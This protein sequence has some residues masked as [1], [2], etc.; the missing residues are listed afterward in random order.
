MATIQETFLGQ[1]CYRIRIHEE[2]FHMQP[3]DNWF[4]LYFLL[5]YLFIPSSTYSSHNP[6]LVASTSLHSA[7]KY[8]SL[9]HRA[10]K[11]KS[12]VGGRPRLLA[13]LLSCFSWMGMIDEGILLFRHLCI[14]KTTHSSVISF[15]L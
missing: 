5:M 12:I 13:L 14:I 4:G 9:S 10:R 7:P 3:H 1:R 8:D 2:G 15:S 6:L 11:Q